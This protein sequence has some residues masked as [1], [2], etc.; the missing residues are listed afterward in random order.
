MQTNLSIPALSGVSARLL[1]LDTAEVKDAKTAF[2]K[3]FEDA[4]SG[5]VGA[6]GHTQIIIINPALQ[7]GDNQ[8]N[9]VHLN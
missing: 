8:M 9:T 3:A 6:Q 2:N 7:S 5:R 1:V 4:L